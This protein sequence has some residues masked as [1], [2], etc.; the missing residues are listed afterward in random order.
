M[1]YH[2]GKYYKTIYEVMDEQ[3][4]ATR[5]SVQRE[6]KR[7]ITYVHEYCGT[8]IAKEAKVALLYCTTCKASFR[9]IPE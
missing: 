2:N 9:T 6:V 3:E 1:I 5:K 8:I 4:R 7:L